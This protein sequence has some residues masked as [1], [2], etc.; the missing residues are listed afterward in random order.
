MKRLF[1][2]HVEPGSPLIEEVCAVTEPSA[3]FTKDWV[4][5]V[6]MIPTLQFFPEVNELL[7]GEAAIREYLETIRPRP[8]ARARLPPIKT[9]VEPKSKPVAPKAEAPK[10][11]APKAEAPKPVAPKAE[12]PK[13]VAPKAEAP[14]PVAP[15]AEAPKPVAPKAEAPKPVVPKAEAPKPVVP[16]AEAPKQPKMTNEEVLREVRSELTKEL[17]KT[18]KKPRK[19]VNIQ[20]PIT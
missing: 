20:K 3:I 5:P 8:M 19:T 6:R 9:K 16:K 15:K 17:K 18:T 2:L 13:P 4:A 1:Y 12:A 14:K 10:P 7:E 11:V